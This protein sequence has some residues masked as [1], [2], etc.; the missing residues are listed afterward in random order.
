M[1]DNKRTY[2]N[3]NHPISELPGLDK[4]LK[5]HL[6]L[7]RFRTVEQLESCTKEQLLELN[8]SK[9]HFTQVRAAL[10]KHERFVAYIE[11]IFESE[12]LTEEKVRQ[13]WPFDLLALPFSCA[14]LG[15]ILRWQKDVGGRYGEQETFC[16]VNGRM[17]YCTNC[18]YKDERTNFCGWCMRKILEET[19]EGKRREHRPD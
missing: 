4:T 16:V 15:Y 9:N 3:P 8:Y 18:R 1:S 14:H 17:Y 2:W 11:A 5:H 19:R 13:F 10:K 7:D 12:G 6:R